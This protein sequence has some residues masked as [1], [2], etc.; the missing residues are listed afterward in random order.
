[1][2]TQYRLVRLE[3]E[4]AQLRPLL[5][6]QPFALMH[7]HPVSA[8]HGWSASLPNFSTSSRRRQQEE[9]PLED[10]DSEEDQPISHLQPRP[11]FREPVLR[12]IGYDPPAAPG[13]PQKAAK[14]DYYRRR[15]IAAGG[16]SPIKNAGS[17]TTFRKGAS[18]AASSHA[19][20]LSDARPEH[21]L[22]AARKIG[23][24]RATALTGAF[25]HLQQLTSAPAPSTK[26]E[27]PSSPQKTNTKRGGHPSPSKTPKT[28]K[29]S[30][31][32]TTPLLTRTPLNF[33]NTTGANAN[34][35]ISVQRTPLQSLLSA[36]QSVLSA[37]PGSS[38]SKVRMGSPDSPLAKKRKLDHNSVVSRGALEGSPRKGKEREVDRRTSESGIRGNEGESTPKARAKSALDFLADQAAAYSSH[39]QAPSQASVE[40]ED[41]DENGGSQSQEQSQ[42]QDYNGEDDAESEGDAVDVEMVD[43]TLQATREKEMEEMTSEEVVPTRRSNRIRAKG[44]QREKS[45]T[46]QLPAS[47]ASVR[48]VDDA[49]DDGER[50]TQMRV[51]TQ[52]QAQ[53]RSPI[54]PERR[55]RVGTPT[56]SQGGTFSEPSQR[57][58]QTWGDSARQATPSI[59]TPPNPSEPLMLAPP[60]NLSPRMSR[61]P[62]PTSTQTHTAQ[63]PMSTSRTSSR[64]QSAERPSHFADNLSSSGLNSSGSF[65]IFSLRRPGSSMF[66]LQRPQ[67]L[68][69][70]G[71]SLL[72]QGNSQNLL[73]EQG[74]SM[75]LTTRIDGVKFIAEDP[76]HR[77]RSPYVKWT[78]EEDELLA[79]VSQA[80]GR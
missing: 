37:P 53:S 39:S 1:M 52:S 56:A 48:K 29:R 8:S 5:L 65:N 45:G 50:E 27:L 38:R 41:G 54:K 40:V 13:S 58:S 79:K 35:G 59:S 69:A 61:S 75:L 4:L 49:E 17:K 73:E 72:Q 3:T 80:D 16:S 70:A 63:V 42:G 57:S 67:P 11:Q 31:M 24:Q 6:M 68:A 10:L 33:T 22:L 7:S 15:D 19:P 76:P 60:I 46:T 12:P 23:M 26:P 66:S 47:M 77:T 74:P 32:P 36:A 78:K 2:D 21:L 62:A 9:N 25:S 18:A 28:P 20:L 43:A 30:L 64:S 55:S 71:S 51:Q 44:K 14:G 34:H